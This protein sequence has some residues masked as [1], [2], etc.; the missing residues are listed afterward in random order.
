MR[1][2]TS[3]LLLAVACEP[4]LAFQP[5]TPAVVP[6]PPAGLEGE[7]YSQ[8]I[9]EETTS[10]A[11]VLW[12]VDNS[13]S[14]SEEQARI[15]DNAPY[16]IDNFID[17]DTL[18][19]HMAFVTTDMYTSAG[20]GLMVPLATGGRYM[21]KDTP[22]V[23]PAFQAAILQG[24]GGPAPERGLDASFLALNDPLL[25]NQNSGFYREDAALH[26]I[27]ISD[28]RDYSQDIS[29]NEYIGWLLSLKASNDIPVTFSAIVGVQGDTCPGWV[30]PGV[31]YIET[32][33]ALDGIILSM[34]EDDWTPALEAIGLLASGNK[35][36]YFLDR[37]PWVDSLEVFITEPSGNTYELDYGSTFEYNDRRNSVSLRGYAPQPGAEAL[38]RYIPLDATSN[39][40]IEAL[41]NADEP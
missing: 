16:F 36:E 23:T 14:M 3:V 5:P 10:Q 7:W 38:I 11:D 30:E 6:N 26:I 8:R 31:G 32:A 40:A 22:G 27:V 12:V 15:A 29:T 9:R 37:V 34:C 2:L 33:Q 28:Q 19:W 1:I 18:D 13:C 4:E 24:N 21:T 41:L 17:D 39:D 25:S 35:V 20:N